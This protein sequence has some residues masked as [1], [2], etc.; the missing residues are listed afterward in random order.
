[1]SYIEEIRQKIGHERLIYLGAGVIVYQKGKILLQKRKDNGA[2]ALHAGG[3][4][5]GEQLCETARREL[6]EETG[7]VA[8]NME[9]FGLYSGEDRVMTYP[10]GD[11]IYMP[12]AFYLCTAFSKTL[13]PQKEEVLDLKWFSTDDLPQKIHLPN[14]RVIKDF[15]E[16]I[17]KKELK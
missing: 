16:F 13:V 10:N 11:Q 3:V 2:W 1:M 5:W 15:L 6:F 7:S 12:N 9:F 4:E 14:R 8:Q 17:E